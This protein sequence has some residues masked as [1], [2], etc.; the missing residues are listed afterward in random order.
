MYQLL[1]PNDPD[2]PSSSEDGQEKVLAEPSRK[3]RWYAWAVIVCIVCTAANLA[4]IYIFPPSRTIPQSMAFL[5]ESPRLTRQEISRLRHPNQFV[6]LNR[7]HRYLS[8]DVRPFIN[9]PFLSALVNESR[10]DQ[11]FFHVDQKTYVTSIGTVS[12]ERHRIMMDPTVSTVLQF[13]ALDY[14]MEACELRISLPARH[15]LDGR[16]IEATAETEFTISDLPTS[17]RLSQLDMSLPLDPETISYQTRP[18]TLRDIADFDIGELPAT[19]SYNFTCTMEEV[20]TFR[21]G[22]QSPECHIEWWQDH[23]DPGVALRQHSSL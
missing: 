21:L 15:P 7:I 2:N 8:S 11:S 17:I 18:P 16:S 23:D 14:G 9:K 4:S 10:P 19:F 6:G 5:L 3:S 13:R 20:L 1:P 22:C 12:P